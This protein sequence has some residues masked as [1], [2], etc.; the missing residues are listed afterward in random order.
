MYLMY[1]Y[2]N[3]HSRYMFQFLH[4]HISP[5]KGQ[6]LAHSERLIQG[7]EHS[8]ELFSFTSFLKRCPEMQAV[9][10]KTTYPPSILLTGLDFLQPR[11]L[12]C[13]CDLT[14]LEI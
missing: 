8:Y 4:K 1:S 14:K 7:V 10:F 3:S 9:S 11:P 2:K 12:S 6:A 13:K 5:N